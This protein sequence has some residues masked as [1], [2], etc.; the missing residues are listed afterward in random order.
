MHISEREYVRI[1]EL[2]PILC[3]DIALIYQGRCLLL[4]RLNQPA[5]GQW[6]FPGGRVLKNELIKDAAL[7][8][9][10]AEVG[11]AGEFKRILSIEETIFRKNNGM[12]S[13]IHTVNVCCHMTVQDISSLNVDG[14]H[15]DFR[16][17]DHNEIESL[18]LHPAVLQPLVMA[19]SQQ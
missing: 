9:S 8:K 6:W 4:Q 11:L 14:D 17:V 3:V 15:S 10:Q 16:W 19:L 5:Q 13:D 12:K 2:L 18:N 7:R 1:Q